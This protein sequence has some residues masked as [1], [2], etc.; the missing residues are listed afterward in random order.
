MTTNTAIQCSLRQ[1]NLHYI[2]HLV[3]HVSYIRRITFTY[4]STITQTEYI[5]MDYPSISKTITDIEALSS[6]IDFILLSEKNC[7]ISIQI[8]FGFVT[9]LQNDRERHP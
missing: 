4:Q 2:S 7:L 5:E 6:E 8:L 9:A 1:Q 3:H